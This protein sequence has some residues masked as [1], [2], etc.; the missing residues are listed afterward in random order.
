MTHKESRAYDGTIA[1]MTGGEK[2]KVKVTRKYRVKIR[3]KTN[4]RPRI[5]QTMYD[6]SDKQRSGT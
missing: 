2:M 5:A 6:K 1:K 3:R 4:R